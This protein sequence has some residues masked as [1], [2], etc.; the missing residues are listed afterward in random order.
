MYYHAACS[1]PNCRRR[2]HSRHALTGSELCGA[3]LTT[4][5]S[6]STRDPCSVCYQSST[7]ASRESDG[8]CSA[9]HAADRWT[10][11]A[12]PDEIQDTARTCS[13]CTTKFFIV[14]NWE[15]ASVTCGPCSAQ[16]VTHT[17]HRS[18]FGCSKVYTRDFGRDAKRFNVY[19]NWYL[20]DKSSYACDDCRR[21]VYQKLLRE[22]T[23]TVLESA[24]YSRH[25]HRYPDRSNYVSV[26]GLLLRACASCA[27]ESTGHRVCAC[28]TV[29]YCNMTCQ[30]R[31]W[32]YHGMTCSAKKVRS[33]DVP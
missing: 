32:Y 24:N 3:C 7:C 8:R 18:C 5:S 27:A 23:R 14:W 25:D 15:G 19:K 6:P 1:D 26:K 9:C 11:E 22:T 20:Y 30:R 29:A 33:S 10:V 17:L 28:L 31:D 4:A 21:R 16:D 2:V 13:Q 12:L